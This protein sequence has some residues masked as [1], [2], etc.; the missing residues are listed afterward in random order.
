MINQERSYL[1]LARPFEI[2]N[3]KERAVFRLYEML[4][5]I[6]SWGTLIFFVFGAR[7]FPEQ[8]SFFLIIF[9]LFWLLRT[10]YFTILLYSGFK[11]TRANEKINWQ[12]RLKSLALPR[13]SLPTI[14]SLED[15]WHLIIIP[16]YKEPEAV[17]QET[18]EALKNSGYSAE[19]MIV[20]LGFEER[21]GREAKTRA[22]KI[23]HEYK[24]SF[25]Q[26]L[27]TFHPDLPGEL[28]GKGANEAYIGRQV[29]EK[30][31]KPAKIPLENIIATVLDADSQIKP[32]YFDCLSYHYL[33]C[34]KPLRSSFQPIPLYTN[35][36][37]QAP[38][39]SRILAFSTTFW[40]MI[41]QARPEIMITYSSQSIGFKPVVEIGFWQ[42]NLISEDSRIFYQCFL[43]FNGD[44]QVVPL[45]FPVS[46]DAN[47]G[48]HLRETIKNLYKQQRR[49][50]YG[51]ENIPYLLYGYS[52]NKKIP[53][54][55]R[56]AH[57]FNIIE[58]FHSWSTHSIILF[59]LGWLPLWLGPYN[60]KFTILSYNLPQIAG[61]FMT[62]S[63]VGLLLTAYLAMVLMPKKSMPMTKTEKLWLF[64]Q[65]LLG[66]LAIFVSTLP[67]LDAVTRLLLGKYLGFWVT[68]KTRE[69]RLR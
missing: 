14:K 32:G 51:A 4:P 59:F 24:N 35:N 69:Q 21:E 25:H 57:A 10:V 16:T 6:L 53:F 50:A 65:W 18:L 13:T 22:R 62:I 56:L 3:K 49:W 64:F 52:K 46:M 43:H 54:K 23:E 2:K 36:I 27:T 67:A 55:E 19:K 45:Y 39:I 58:G 1:R 61:F 7:F 15:L 5:G 30:I 8:I 68:P 11:K 60:F 26:F 40:Q 42:E 44:W 12:Q 63:M 34:Q 47:Y 20:A 66:P 17:L 38:A 9:I 31:I 28:K 29:L 41:Q 33:S 37:W 48:N